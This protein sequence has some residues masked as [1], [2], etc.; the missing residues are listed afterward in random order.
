MRGGE[1]TFVLGAKGIVMGKD[2]ISRIQEMETRTFVE[3]SL[4]GSLKPKLELSSTREEIDQSA[5]KM[6]LEGTERP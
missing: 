2:V 3:H 1:R 6:S 5:I 4:L